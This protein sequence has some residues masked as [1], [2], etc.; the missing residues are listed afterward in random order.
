MRL[1]EKDGRGRGCGIEVAGDK[2]V[3]KVQDRGLRRE[4]GKRVER[5]RGGVMIQTLCTINNLKQF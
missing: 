2:W 1:E 4:G 5:R 3:K